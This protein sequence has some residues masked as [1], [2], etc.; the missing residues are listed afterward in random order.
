MR[1]ADGRLLH[2]YVGDEA[3]VRATAEDYAYL[4]WG[5]INLYEATFDLHYLQAAVALQKEFT[6]HF[7][8]AQEGGYFTAPDD[9][10]L[11]VRRKSF[12]DG[13]RPSAN[14]V[15]A[16][17]L[18]RLSGLTGDIHLREQA[19]MLLDAA[20]PQVR[21]HPD[22]FAMLL[23]ALDYEVGPSFEV[24]IVGPPDA[25]GARALLDAYFTPYHP[26]SVVVLHDPDDAAIDQTISYVSDHRMLDGQPTAYVC[27]NFGCKQPTTDPN[28]MLALM[29]RAQH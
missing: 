13:S 20:A 21:Q 7:W 6:L 8:D 11:P 1:D 9:T 27:Q 17:N 18:L 24:V 28:R 16:L 25:P 12:D 5:L 22:G 10:D 23:S 19:E 2:R 14:S 29:G 15:A 4:I 3:G 26:N